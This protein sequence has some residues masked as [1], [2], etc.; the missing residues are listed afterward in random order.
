MA[1]T[2]HP[3]SQE[4]CPPYTD[5]LIVDFAAPTDPTHLIHGFA[6]TNDH[7][8][9]WS[10]ELPD[11]PTYPGLLVKIPGFG[12]I[13]STSRNF[14]REAALAGYATVTY[15][16]PR[17][18]D[19][20]LWSTA[21]DPHTTHTD[22]LTAID[23]SLAKN[24]E[25]VSALAERGLDLHRKI[26]TPHSMGGIP[27]VHY[28]NR[29]DSQVDA[30][31]NMA[32]AGY[33]HPTIGEIARHFPINIP[34][35]VMRELLPGFRDGSIELSMTNLKA[36]V[37]YYVRARALM[38]MVS[39]LREDIRPQAE[40]VRTAGTYIGYIAF[41]RD[42]LVRPTPDVS[43]HVDDYVVMPKY[44]HIAPMVRAKQVVE[45]VRRL[46]DLALAA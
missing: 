1:T 15:E 26:L 38:E 30:I 14:S 37:N 9:G 29:G 46:H 18:N 13:Q 33:G 25:A 2:M 20:D 23:A 27:A 24:P 36:I 45:E 5:E 22:T 32:A 7:Q 31:V 19:V 10:L 42:I 11:Q 3:I 16:P 40:R 28:A 6:E 21:H 4:V 34:N 41:G 39:C 12:G 43:E 44:G 35:S 8:V 17:H